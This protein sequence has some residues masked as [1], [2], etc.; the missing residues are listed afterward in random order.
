MK[1]I[2]AL[3]GALLSLLLFSTAFFHWDLSGGWEFLPR[4]VPRF[5]MGRFLRQIPQ[6]LHWLAIF[7]L[8]TAAV[9]PMRA[10]Q[11]QGA[12]PE[13]VPFRERY[14]LLAIGVFVNN[15]L[16]GKLGDLTRSFLMART[17]NLPFAT[18]LGSVAVC[19][20]LEFYALML[21][22]AAALLSP[23]SHALKPFLGGLK[24]ALLALALLSM[25]LWILSRS[26]GRWSARLA[27][28]KHRWG[29]IARPLGQL[30][31]GLG[32]AR[33]SR[34]LAWVGL[35]SI[36]P[37]LAPAMGY[38]FGLEAI[39]VSGG[40]FVG[41]LVL[42]TI[43]LG[44]V[45]GLPATIGIYYLLTS[46]IARA[47]GAPE[48]AAA[49]YAAL[50]HLASLTTLLLLGTASVLIRRLKWSE[51]RRGSAQAREALKMPRRGLEPPCSCER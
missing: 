49:A 5:P 33:S 16:P 15:V 4:P 14:H 6:N 38:G 42:G 32:A 26:A 28:S 8:F 34:R 18:A 43:A 2:G 46:W 51:L 50:T 40:L 36:P 10:L 9:V 44:Q 37:V 30:H 25:F 17:R 3:A 29:W 41:P 35:L 47:L 21:I 7:S 13:R 39:G 1:A 45:P 31:S 24:W 11:W 20:L 12:L 22:L 19:K 27:A 23:L 48:E